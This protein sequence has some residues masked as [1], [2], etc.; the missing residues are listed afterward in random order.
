MTVA[1]ST[2]RALGDPVPGA[3]ADYYRA[4]DRH[5]LVRA[6]EAFSEDALYAV[7][8]LGSIET[9][10]RVA[11]VGR[12]ALLAWFE[13][14]GPRTWVHDV[15]LCTVDGPACLLE[16]VSHDTGDG[17]VLASFVASLRLAGDGTIARYLAWGTTPAV[18]PSP[19]DAAP[20]TDPTADAGAVLGR[21]FDAL[22]TGDFDAAAACFSPDVVYSHP[23]YRHTGIDGDRRVELRGR[24]ALLANFRARGRQ[25]FDHRLLACVQRGP[26]CLVEGRVENIPGGRD[27]S[28]VSS[29]TLDG[30]GLVRRYVSFYCEPAVRVA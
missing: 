5:D 28:F 14:R 20:A 24:A 30:D 17:R 19:A 10:P 15:L 8:P 18:T 13:D 21:Y 16:G 22:D 1:T 23:P 6:T 26:H 12:A 11:T 27:G 7:P 25:S 29:L 4:L 9:A 3:V 2:E